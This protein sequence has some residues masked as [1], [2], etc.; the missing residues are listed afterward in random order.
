MRNTNF[1]KQTDRRQHT[2]VLWLA[3]VLAAMTILI[4]IAGCSGGGGGGGNNSGGG[5]S[6]APTDTVVGGG[7]AT[8]T[9][10]W[11]E[12]GPQSRHIP[13]TADRLVIS[14]VDAENDACYYGDGVGCRAVP[15]LADRPA[16]RT[17]S[18]MITLN[19]LP[20]RRRL[21]LE[22][23]AF[24]RSGADVNGVATYEPT[25]VASGSGSF[26][27][28][29]EPNPNPIPNATV[30]LVETVAKLNVYRGAVL[31]N[32]ETTTTAT[33]RLRPTG[34]VNDFVELRV[35]AEDKDGNIVLLRR[36][37][38]GDN[39]NPDLLWEKNGDTISGTTNGI[40]LQGGAGNAQP[41]TTGTVS[42]NVIR[43][44]RNVLNTSNGVPLGERAG[45]YNITVV[46]NG[47]T[48]IKPTANVLVAVGQE[49]ETALTVNPAIVVSTPN[50]APVLDIAI[51]NAQP[52]L[53]VP[54]NVNTGTTPVPFT[55][56][57]S[58]VPDARYLPIGTGNTSLLITR[59]AAL[60]GA[61]PALV[62]LVGNNLISLVQGTS[63]DL[64]Q[65]TGF[66]VARP[67]D[68]T[69]DTMIAPG[70][71]IITAVTPTVPSRTVRDIATNADLSAVYALVG[72]PMTPPPASP[73][74]T[75]AVR[76]QRD[77]NS[78]SGLKVINQNPVPSNSQHIAIHENR[79]VLTESSVI[80]R[81]QMNA[82][83]PSGEAVGSI[84]DIATENGYLYVL[85]KTLA[86]PRIH[87]FDIA[88]FYLYSVKAQQDA[89]LVNAAHMSAYRL[90]GVE[91]R[92]AVAYKFG[93][94]AGV[95]EYVRRKPQ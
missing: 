94:S 23:R 77:P 57:A 39:A 60:N 73:S 58:Q 90:S 37:G 38:Q 79:V 2:A 69:I 26:D 62:G 4:G 52:F 30:T 84:D 71:D 32:G 88:G 41:V 34:P 42:G 15:F 72:D 61:T 40:T 35:E 92:V 49:T 68:T 70:L 18:Q 89:D 27:A 48:A 10:Q 63:S 95:L 5:G 36:F 56:L 16:E 1:P 44:R 85:D 3:G 11:P 51:D 53:L 13:Y 9:I 19:N 93:S 17:T 78:A 45:V 33:S 46:Y 55:S 64:T 82:S 80:G 24:V 66:R 6:A 86:R 81:P 54:Q 21:R 75:L 12:I 47:E 14:V 8:L 7:R 28:P 65:N 74:E 76:I 25:P 87:V 20:V 67:F 91:G 83:N 59:I 50:D 43:V 31:L 22:M 29:L